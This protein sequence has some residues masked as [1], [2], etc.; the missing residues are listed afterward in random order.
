[1]KRGKGFVSQAEGHSG[2]VNPAQ[3]SVL[4]SGKPPVCVIPGLNQ[5]GEPSPRS[6]GYDLQLEGNRRW[7]MIKYMSSD[8]MTK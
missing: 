6:K 8:H 5:Q 1:M 4:A 2:L 7:H 3:I